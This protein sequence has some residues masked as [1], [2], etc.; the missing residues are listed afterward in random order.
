[1]GKSKAPPPPDYSEATR[2]GVYSD[3]ETLPA[4]RKIESAARLGQTAAY[5]DP[6]TGE[7]VTADFTG[8]GAVS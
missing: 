5:T 1:M 4:R 3:I 6:R 7:D 2:E 8:I